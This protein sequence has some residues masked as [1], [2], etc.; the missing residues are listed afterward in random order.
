[1]EGGAEA[2]GRVLD[3]LDVAR[4]DFRRAAGQDSVAEFVETLAPRMGRQLVGTAAAKRHRPATAQATLVRRASR[5]LQ[6][7][8]DAPHRK[9]VVWPSLQAGTVHISS[10]IAEQGGFRPMQLVDD[11]AP[12]V[13]GSSLRFVAQTTTV[14][15]PFKVFWQ[16]VNTGSAATAARDLRGGFEEPSVEA[17]TLTKRETASYTGSHSIECFIVK[18]GYCAARSGPFVVNIA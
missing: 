6:R 17:G 4:T 7:I 16:V 15:R 10:A 13:K 9:L 11:G 3:W 12:V 2:A 1:M 18:D 5:A 14:A 8:L